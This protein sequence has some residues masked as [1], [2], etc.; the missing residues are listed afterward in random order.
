MN[1]GIFKDEALHQASLLIRVNGMSS[2]AQDF[3][4]LEGASVIAIIKLQSLVHAAGCPH[5]VT[6]APNQ[7]PVTP[8]QW[9][10]FITG[11]VGTRVKP[12]VCESR[13]G[14]PYNVGVYT[15]CWPPRLPTACIYDL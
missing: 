3:V 6:H 5:T 2:Q 1:G 12:T 13:P 7:W 9:P 8:H 10:V 4:F 15:E 11:G 14:L